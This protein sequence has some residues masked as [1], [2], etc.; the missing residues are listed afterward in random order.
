MVAL[1]LALDH[2]SAVRAL[3]LLSGYYFRTLR[4]DVLAFSPMAAPIL[5]NLLSYTAPLLG[6]A[7][8]WRVVRKLFAPAAV[9]PCFAAEFPSELSLRPSQLKASALETVLMTPSAAALAK[10]Y[11]ELKMPVIIIAGRGDRI[12]DF[13]RQSKRL[14]AMLPQSQLI[15]FAGAGHMVHHIVPAQVVEGIDLAAGPSAIA[16]DEITPIIAGAATQNAE[17]L[18]GSGAN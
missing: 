2:P 12:V 16:E 13:A 9:S 15:S 18:R 7:L 6:R 10:R 17:S 4:A 14:N 11:R 1:S 8:W 3:V 5:G